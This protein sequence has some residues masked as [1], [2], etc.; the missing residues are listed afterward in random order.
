MMATQTLDAMAGLLAD[1]DR[2]GPHMAAVGEL[3]CAAVEYRRWGTSMQ[4]S[5]HDLTREEFDSHE[6]EETHFPETADRPREWWAKTVRIWQGDV[7]VERQPKTEGHIWMTLFTE[8]P[9]AAVFDD[10]NDDTAS[11]PV[12]TG[13]HARNVIG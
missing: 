10:R 13:G 9:P 4:L 1:L 5:I 12:Q 8:E 2:L 11:D 6:G 7:D 3:C